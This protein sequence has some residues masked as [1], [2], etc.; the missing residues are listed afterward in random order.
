MSGAV[1]YLFEEQQHHLRWKKPMGSGTFSVCRLGLSTYE[2]A[3]T[4]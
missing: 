3:I 2:C 1:Q 4:G